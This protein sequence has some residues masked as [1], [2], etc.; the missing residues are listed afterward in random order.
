MNKRCEN[1]KYYQFNTVCGFCTYGND[2]AYVQKFTVCD[3][4]KPKFRK[5]PFEGFK[6]YLD[7]PETGEMRV[8][9]ICEDCGREMAA[10][11]HWWYVMPMK[12]NGNPSTNVG[13]HFQCEKCHKKNR[14]LKL[15][16]VDE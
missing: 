8:A 3:N 12:V 13:Y 2:N 11:A 7:N 14:G 6:F 5:S 4:Y 15:T 10:P 1:C 16:K 9:Y